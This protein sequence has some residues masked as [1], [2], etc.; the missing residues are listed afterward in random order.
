MSNKFTWFPKFTRMLVSLPNDIKV[1]MLDAVMLYGTDGIEP[2]FNGDEVKKALFEGFREDIDASVKAR[3]GNKGG[4][5][6]KE[7]PSKNR[8]LESE[9]PR[10][11]DKN[12][13]LEN[14]NGGL[15]SKNPS[16][17]NNTIQNNTEHNNTKQEKEKEKEKPK[18]Q[19]PRFAP[20]S[21]S[22]IEDYF[23]VYA[24]EK[25]YAID[26]TP[27]KFFNFYTSNGWKVGKNAMKDWKA[28]LR[29]WIARDKSEKS[30]V[31]TLENNPCP[32]Y[33]VDWSK[34]GWG[35]VYTG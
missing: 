16:L 33:G 18:T 20:P 24:T 22:E 6:S 27:A 30:N 28:A 9:N 31:Q 12:R 8:G 13:G 4:R 5:P 19:N 25:G 34:E 10:F 21:L 17:Y 26:N 1:E 2:N 35:N 15:E 32:A 29:G 3:T 11:E 23:T 7:N 14:G